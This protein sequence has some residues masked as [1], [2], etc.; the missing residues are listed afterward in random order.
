MAL[1]VNRAAQ[2]GANILYRRYLCREGVETCAF[3]TREALGRAD[4]FAGLA[5]ERAEIDVGP[6]SS[7]A[8]IK[9]SLEAKLNDCPEFRDSVERRFPE[10]GFAALFSSLATRYLPLHNPSGTANPEPVL[11]EV[12]ELVGTEPNQGIVEAA[13]FFHQETA[14]RLALLFDEAVP[15]PW[16]QLLEMNAI[17]QSRTARN[18]AQVAGGSLAEAQLVGLSLSGGGIRSA[19]LNLGILQALADLKLLR[20]LDYL[21]TVSGGGYIGSWLHAWIHRS[22]GRKENSE[23]VRRALSPKESPDPDASATRPIK[24]LRRYSNYLAP[25]LGFLSADV[26]SIA[27]LWMRNTLLNLLVITLALSAVL[28]VPRVLPVV[29][30][31]V[32]MHGRNPLWI[33][34]LLPL[35]FAMVVIQKN[36]RSF[37]ETGMRQGKW[38]FQQQK[39]IH[40]AVAF[41]VLLSALAAAAWLFEISRGAASLIWADVTLVSAFFILLCFVSFGGDYRTHFFDRRLNRPEGLWAWAQ[42]AGA[43]L[44][45]NGICA[46]AGALLFS[47]LE[48]LFEKWKGEYAD[49]NCLVW[50][51]VLVALG[52]WLVLVL[53]V[54]LFGRNL[55][56]DRREWWSRLGAVFAIWM[57][58]WV[59]LAGASIYGPPVLIRLANVGY[60]YIL[61][62]I[63]AGWIGSTVTGV[64]KANSA[65]TG[66]GADGGKATGLIIRLAPPIF[67]AGFLVLLALVDKLA[68]GR[69]QGFGA[70]EPAMAAIGFAVCL[71]AAFL[72][73]WRVDVNEFSMHNFYENRL[74]RCYLGA[75]RPA[76]QPN[77]FT[78]FDPDDDIRVADLTPPG[79]PGEPG[80]DG[81]YPLVNAALNL[82]SGEELAWQERKAESFVFTPLFSGFAATPTVEGASGP[83]SGPSRSM[84]AYRPTNQYAFP[85]GGIRLGRA[86]AI[87]GAAASPNQGYHTSAPAAFLMTVFNVRLGWWIGNPRDTQGWRR[88]GPGIGL[89]YLLVELAAAANNRSRYVYLSDGGHFENLGMYELV[90]RRCRYIVACDGGQ[91]ASFS[92]EDLGNAIRKCRADFGVE[93]EIDLNSIRPPAAEPGGRPRSAAHCAVGVIHYPD[94][95]LGTLVYIKA[96][97]TG[98]EPADVLEYATLHGEFPHQST[99]DQFFDESQFE[100]YRRLGHHI[101]SAV[102]GE[103]VE[104]RAGRLRDDGAKID[105]DRAGF[106]SEVRWRWYA[107]SPKTDK[108]FTRHA[109]ALTTLMRRLGEEPLLAFLDTQMSPEWERLMKGASGTPS[110]PGLGLP[111]KAE[112]RRAGFYFCN[113]LMQLMEDVYLDLNLAEESDHPDN[114][115]WMNL[116]QHWSWSSM[117]RATWV[118]SASCYG[119]RFR[120]FCE[121]ELGLDLA[122]TGKVE[123]VHAS[124]FDDVR[125]NFREKE[126]LAAAAFHQPEQE[127]YLAQALVKRPDPPHDVMV[128]LTVALIVVSR[129]NELLYL[130]VQEHLRNM[131]LARRILDAMVV[132]RQCPVSQAPQWHDLPPEF[133]EPVTKE[134]KERIERLL[135]SA[136][137]RLKGVS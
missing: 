83:K 112:E 91:D 70:P 6:E 37:G 47:L 132:G 128:E 14:A 40:I 13:L 2:L 73:A 96:S 80:Y 43:T 92:F 49:W 115:G 135:D 77:R 72:L 39:W 65:R 27:A 60:G 93:I 89:W 30:Y 117:F 35:V 121:N 116:F 133:P 74:V 31:I 125:L 87:S 76:R 54:G 41:P 21:S 4:D 1:D 109:E 81:P 33:G 122:T 103:I 119:A 16:V 55:L 129:T 131:G 66:A 9:P 59:A 113:A 42:F 106:F 130:R 86:M 19:T 61:S 114:S 51:T 18:V 107:A 17:G 101:G 124:G 82:V 88:S 11:V 126:L 26:L 134:N 22:K 111:L 95:P 50:G 63:G 45:C 79:K 28:M 120:S 52:Y 44:L 38:W 84:F 75:S 25:R 98:D 90:R 53:H 3:W 123:I 5:K 56:D 100:S 24:W 29:F 110:T 104:R 64:M 136:H 108:S 105:A 97:L 58:G 71:V 46:I 69:L 10:I 118:I 67:V 62:L 137:M 94:A 7:I 85:N 23:N 68:L 78:G 34:A 48:R 12:R 15:F 36:L 102:F 20:H 57:A 32:R 127:L 8:S 99:A